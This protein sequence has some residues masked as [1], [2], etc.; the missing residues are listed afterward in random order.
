MQGHPL[1]CFVG[2]APL[3]AAHPTLLQS[4]ALR[5]EGEQ[6]CRKDTGKGKRLRKW[7]R[8]HQ[9]VVR[10]GGHIDAWQPLYRYAWFV[11]VCVCVCVCVSSQRAHASLHTYVVCMWSAAQCTCYIAQHI[12]PCGLIIIVGTRPWEA[13]GV[14]EA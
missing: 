13:V 8:G 7:S 1:L 14:N 9:F 3:L 5:E 11:C 12:V 6:L 4:V 10:G 2:V